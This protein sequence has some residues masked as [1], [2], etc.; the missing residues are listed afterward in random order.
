MKKIFRYI[1]V[2]AVIYALCFS[3]CS[4]DG[5]SST[6]SGGLQVKPG[7]TGEINP[8]VMSAA[9]LAKNL[10]SNNSK[11]LLLFYIDGASNYT[12]K[13][14]YMWTSGKDGKTSNVAFENES[15]NSYKYGKMCLYDGSTLAAGLPDYLTDC[16]VNGTDASILVKNTGS[17]WSWQTV[18]MILP[19]SSGNKHFLITSSNKSKDKSE[20]YELSDNILPAIT[21]AKMENKTEMKVSLGVKLGLENTASS[22]GFVLKDKDGNEIE[23]I[24]AKN[25]DYKDKE[26]RSHNF[27]DTVYLKL[28]QEI[29]F[30]NGYYLSR[31]GFSPENGIKVQTNTSA[32]L[33][34][35]DYVYKDSDLGLTLSENG[36]RATFKTWAPLANNVQLL[37]FKDVNSLENPDEIE[38]MDHDKENGIWSASDIDVASYNYYKFRIKNGTEENDVCDIYAK[39]CS[40]DSVAAQIVDI[41]KDSDSMPAG[42]ENEY[43]NPFGNTKSEKKS[44]TDAVIYEMHIRDWSRL[45]GSDSTGKFLDI[46]EGSKVINHIK[47]LGVTH[48]QILPMFDY[49]QTNSDNNYNWG[50]NPYHYNVPEGRY[51]KDMVNGTDAVKQ[52]RALIKAFHDAGIAVNMDVVYNHTSGTGTGSLY[53]MTVPYYYYRLDSDGNYS[54]GSGC[55]NETD[56]SAPMFRKYMIESLKHWM[57]DY[58]INGFRFDLMGLHEVETMKEIYREL[59]AVDPNVMVYGEPWQGGTSTIKGGVTKS[60]IDQCADNTYSENGVACFNDD[61]RNAIKGSEYPGFSSGQVSSTDCSVALNLNMNGTGFF[62]KIGRSINYV[63]CHDNLTLSDKLALVMN[64]KT[65]AESGNWVGVNGEEID[66]VV[67]YG[68]ISELKKRDMLA[69]SYMFLAQGTPFINGGQEFLRSKKGDE[70]SYVSDD[71][72]NEIKD[73]YITEYADVTKYYK[74]LISL[75]KTYPEDFGNCGSVNIKNLDTTG[76]RQ[77]YTTS[78]FTVFFNAANSSYTI[79]SAEKVNGKVVTISDGDVKIAESETEISSIP[80]LS[81]VI[82]KNN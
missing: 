26:D 10:D 59:S 70:N 49:A 31:P 9:E 69:A 72:I 13:T 55:G 74:G 79:D 57:L 52:L 28:G 12:D 41:S 44:Y 63:E 43:K 53:D 38:P 51:V 25:Y 22:N 56:S 75:R 1:A 68:R 66:G 48:V 58:H 29:D 60:N 16:F 42:W 11:H 20:I 18:D 81:T 15:Q 34:L 3:S 40:P 46:A 14:A 47:S 45:E 71:D 17:S 4:S 61:L 36:N 80:P 65:K 33:F 64:G 67:K 39:A 76:L 73:S 35:S 24:D 23:I 78:G 32:K 50:Y 77:K 21:S 82:I 8:V 62:S 37:L 19:L 2:F 6:D 7:T 30:S 54:N 27:T 5:S